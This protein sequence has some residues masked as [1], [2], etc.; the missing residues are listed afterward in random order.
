MFK[1]SDYPVAQGRRSRY[2]WWRTQHYSFI[3]ISLTS[4]LPTFSQPPRSQASLVNRTCTSVL[5]SFTTSF[6]Q[7]INTTTQVTNLRWVIVFLCQ[8]NVCLH[9]QLW[10]SWTTHTEPIFHCSRLLFK[11][12][13]K[14]RQRKST[15]SALKACFDK[16]HMYSLLS[17]KEINSFRS[18]ILNHSARCGNVCSVATLYCISYIC[19]SWRTTAWIVFMLQPV[20]L[21]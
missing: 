6:F 11:W 8:S 21:I 15:F 5:V 1:K 20:N 7:L 3:F 19:S 16:G 14:S 13:E 4:P 17:V 12:R 9:Y 2:C 10:A 18:L